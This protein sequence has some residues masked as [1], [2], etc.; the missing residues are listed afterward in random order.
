MIY[1]VFFQITDLSFNYGVR[2]SSTFI[3]DQKTLLAVA[4][5]ISNSVSRSLSLSLAL[6]HTH[7]HTHTHMIYIILLQHTAS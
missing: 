5:S 1:F 2:F 6:S 7:T 4:K 3:E